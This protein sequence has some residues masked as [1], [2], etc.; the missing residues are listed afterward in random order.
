MEVKVTNAYIV[1]EGVTLM[2]EI[3]FRAWLTDQKRMLQTPDS[4]EFNGHGLVAIYDGVKEQT[5]LQSEFELMQYT[6]LKDKNG[7]EI[8]EGDIINIMDINF[9]EDNLNYE[10]QWTFFGYWPRHLMDG[11]DITDGHI[12]IEVIGNIYENPELLK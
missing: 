10:V 12:S 7:K 5:F 8:Y 9:P 11:I 4:L 2:R 3:K 6:G 1:K